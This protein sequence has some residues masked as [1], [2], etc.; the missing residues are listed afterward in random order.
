VREH[1][2]RQA[3][4]A[5]V[6]V[7]LLDGIVILTV[8]EDARLDPAHLLQV[9]FDSGVTV[10]EM[11]MTAKGRVEKDGAGGLLFRVLGPQTFPIAPGPKS[12]ELESL[13]D[14]GQEVRL[15]GRLYQK[16]TGKSKAKPKA[17]LPFELL[18]VNPR[19]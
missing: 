15:R 1:L 13:A 9:T 6:D 4:V 12:K 2:G 8:K 18:E 5:N 19:E 11:T 7:N 14:S 3:G 10:A 17:P 16:P